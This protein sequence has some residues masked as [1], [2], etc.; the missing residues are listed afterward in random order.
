MHSLRKHILF[1]GELSQIVDLYDHHFSSDFWFKN[2]EEKDSPSY[3]LESI[4]GYNDSMT[5]L[6]NAVED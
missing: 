6:K 3:M 1:I 5:T 2:K 4:H